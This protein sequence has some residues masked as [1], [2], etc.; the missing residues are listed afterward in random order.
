M[1]LFAIEWNNNLYARG[2][3]IIVMAESESE[4]VERA[5]KLPEV[6]QR[7]WSSPEP[8]WNSVDEITDG[9]WIDEG[10]DA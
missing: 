2:S 5:K 1:K 10:C 8:D 9:V 7:C 6:V 3:T 4:A